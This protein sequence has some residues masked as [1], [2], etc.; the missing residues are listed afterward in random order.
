[1]EGKE[2]IEIKSAVSAPDEVKIVD[3]AH[4]ELG[5][6]HTANVIME[7]GMDSNGP[8]AKMPPTELGKFLN[9]FTSIANQNLLSTDTPYTTV[10]SYDPWDLYLL[11]PSV[12]DKVTDFSYI[13]GSLEVFISVVAPAGAYGLYVISATPQGY[14]SDS[15]SFGIST[16]PEAVFT[17]P[18]VVVDLAASSSGK[19]KL[20]WI[21][22]M[23]YAT[24]VDDGKGSSPRGMWTL[25]VTCFQPIATGTGSVTPMATLKFWVRCCEDVELVIPFQQG[26]NDEVKGMTGGLKLSEVGNGIASSI[27]KLNG[28]PIIGALSRP[29]AA[30]ASAV[31]SVLDWFGFSRTAEQQTPT[32]VV[33]RP[34]SNLANIDCNDTSEIAAMSNCNSISIDP[35]I[36]SKGHVDETAFDFLFA[37][38]IVVGSFPWLASNVQGDILFR[39]PVTPFVARQDISTGSVFTMAGYVGFPFGYWR[40]DMEYM[41]LIPV[42]KF[43]RGVIQISWCPK[44][45]IAGD[46]T[47]VQ[48]NHIV[49]VTA[50]NTYSFDIGYTR[51]CPML[52]CVPV[53]ATIP[54]PMKHAVMN[55][56]FRVT[57]VNPLTSQVATANTNIFVLARAK[58]NMQF[59]APRDSV[60]VYTGATTFVDVPF[61]T[62][63]QIQGGGALGDEP[64]TNIHFELVPSSGNFP[65]REVCAGEDFK[66]VRGLMQK[67]TQV[68]AIANCFTVS[69]STVFV[70]HLPVMNMA[71]Q[72]TAYGLGTSM[73]PVFHWT[74]YYGAMYVGLAFSTRYKITN[75]EGTYGPQPWSVS[76]K[77]VSRLDVPVVTSYY[78]N[79]APQWCIDVGESVEVTVPWYFDRKYLKGYAVLTANGVFAGTQHTRIDEI[80]NLSRTSAAT[81]LRSVVVYTAA[82]SD[83]RVHKFR[84]LPKIKYVA[85]GSV[86]PVYGN[87]NPPGLLFGDVNNV[88]DAGQREAIID[89]VDAKLVFDGKDD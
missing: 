17:T 23:D 72:S 59:A 51:E 22:P 44:E 49:D 47:N 43:H 69:P 28:I 45:G 31:S 14:G 21:Y 27:S 77:T 56:C 10:V 58:S 53:T 42:S 16:A 3:A 32:V 62:S 26:L 2:R 29:I 50:G 80:R 71:L 35:G 12:S 74:A 61:M 75:C 36:V 25:R 89:G 48:L 79:V 83:I 88:E 70:P 39:F 73:T 67:F 86:G 4:Y 13:R 11:N 33:S 87:T 82:S 40:G 65:I 66:S 30:G 57:V 54:S 20:D 64:S 37:K 68:P 78:G 15:T 84:V 46:I 7:S 19:L 52:E 1:M 41:F 8:L 34:Y 76:H 55:G 24:V 9:R 81:T 6:T 85:A 60:V 38:W 63:F 18:H 5:E